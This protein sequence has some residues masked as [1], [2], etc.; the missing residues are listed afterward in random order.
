M[1]HT[2]LVLTNAV[3]GEEAAFNDW[4]DNIHLP[5]VLRVPGVTRAQRFQTAQPESPYRFCALYQIDASDPLAVVEEIQRR[6]GTEEMP[7]SSLMSSEFLAT[8]YGPTDY[9]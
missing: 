7:I 3:P 8:L 6:A 9:P 4:Y 5:D 2:Y 1:I